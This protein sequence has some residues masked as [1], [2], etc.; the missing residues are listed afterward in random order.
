[1]CV[2]AEP[3]EASR[4]EFMRAR[5]VVHGKERLYFIF[6]IKGHEGFWRHH[7]PNADEPSEHVRA[8]WRGLKWT[9]RR[10]WEFEEQM[11]LIGHFLSW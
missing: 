2:E 7:D 6:K 11:V 4:L 5:E 3:P 8:T 10:A 1:M 9:F